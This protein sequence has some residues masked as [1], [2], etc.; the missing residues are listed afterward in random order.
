MRTAILHDDGYGRLVCGL[1]GGKCGCIEYGRRGHFSAL[2]LAG[3]PQSTPGEVRF[4]ANV[5]V[6]FQGEIPL[7]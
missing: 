1:D 7:W 2:S 6:S 5:H 3:A 4:P